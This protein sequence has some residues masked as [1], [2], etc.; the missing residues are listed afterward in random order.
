MKGSEPDR[1][2][3]SKAGQTPASASS[4]SATPKHVAKPSPALKWLI[5]TAVV[6]FIVSLVF[7]PLLLLELP[8]LVFIIILLIKHVR[9]VNRAEAMNREQLPR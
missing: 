4:Y 3:K 5:P 2:R 6:G 1:P 7:L 9:A 8:L